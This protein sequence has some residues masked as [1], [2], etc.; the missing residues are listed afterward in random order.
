[1]FICL[2]ITTDQTGRLDRHGKQKKMA[3]QRILI[4]LPRKMK[5]EAKAAYHVAAP[6]ATLTD[7][8]S[9]TLFLSQSVFADVRVLHVPCKCVM[10]ILPNRSSTA[11]LCDPGSQSCEAEPLLPHGRVARHLAA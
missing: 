10:P 4:Y 3:K 6:R 2:F 9:L 5:L 11:F 1:M 7:P 8:L